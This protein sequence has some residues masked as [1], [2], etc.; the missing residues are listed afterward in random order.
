M[1]GKTI[2]LVDDSQTVLLMEKTLLASRG[3]RII[4]AADGEECVAKAVAE[5]PHLILMDLMMPKLDGFGAVKRLRET[6][7]TRAIP[8]L[9]VT[10]KSEAHRIEEATNLGCQGYLTKPIN[11]SALLLRVREL[12]GD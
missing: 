12:I 11:G 5:K 1:A 10:T 2:L 4:T 7:A 3:D 6:E 8:V 9:M